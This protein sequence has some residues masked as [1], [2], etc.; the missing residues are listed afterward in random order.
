MD[1]SL[2]FFIILPILIMA[3]RSY[4]KNQMLIFICLRF[5]RLWR[6]DKIRGGRE[7]D[8]IADAASIITDKKCIF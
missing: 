8:R 1:K 6:A 7:V 2:K 3:I 5:S 4:L